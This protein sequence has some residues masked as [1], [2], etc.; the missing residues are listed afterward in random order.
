MVRCL[1][2]VVITLVINF[3]LIRSAEAQVGVM[4]ATR[5]V[6]S[7]RFI[8]APRYIQQELREAE[9]AIEEDRM[10]DAVVRLGDLLQRDTT[11]TADEDLAGQDFFLPPTDGRSGRYTNSKLRRARKLVSQLPTSAIETYELRYGPL[12]RKTLQ[13]AAT[14]RDW[15]AVRDVRRK[16]FHTTA[17]FEASWLLAQH[18]MYTGHPLAASLLLDDVVKLPRAVSYL[19]D[20]IQVLYAAALKLS[21]RSLAEAAMPTSGEVTINGKSVT[22]PTEVDVDEW[23]AT[24]FSYG[25]TRAGGDITSYR[26]FGAQHGRNEI[27]AGQMPLANARWQLETTSTPREARTLEKYAEEL[28]ASSKLPPPS[29]M[30]LRVGDQLLMRTTNYLF[31]VDYNTGK[32]VW[33]YPWYSTDEAFEDEQTP[34]MFSGQRGV[35]SL[36][37][38]RVWNDMPYGQMTSDGRRVFFVD[39]LNEVEAA[40]FSPIMGLQGT[41]PSDNSTNTLVALDLPTE[42]KLLWRLGEGADESSSLSD[43]FFLGPPLPLDGRLYVMVEVAGDILLVCLDSVTGDEIWR[44]QLVA[45]ETGSVDIDITRR[46]SGATPTYSDGVLICPTGAGA[47]VAVDLV[48][49]MLRWGVSYSRRP[50]MQQMMGTRGGSIDPSLLM[51]RWHHG[52]AVVVDDAVFVTPTESDTLM[53]LDLLSGAKRFPDRDREDS[54]YMAGVRDGKILLVGSK[55]LIALDSK[56]GDEQWVTQEDLL[57]PGLQV[58]GRGVFGDNDYLVPTSANQLI[59]IALDDGKV[60]ERRATQYPLGNLLAVDGEVISQGATS[61]SVAYGEA[62]LEPLV[63]AMLK[64]DPTNFEALVRKAELLI[65]RDSRREALKLLQRARDVKSDSVEVRMLSV[66]AMLGLLRE[67]A[68][69]SEQLADQLESMIDRPSERVKFLSLRIRAALKNQEIEQATDRIIQ[70]SALIAGDPLLNHSGEGAVDDV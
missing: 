61:L 25:Q 2:C 47:I 43:A 16:Y 58:V 20:S 22:L 31:G 41:R 35:N 66:A 3:V 10:S 21:G 68:E 7:A 60:L 29:L 18:E 52:V 55:R 70:L 17:G 13:E 24:R 63:N 46:V 51:Q 11:D 30:P 59:R 53:S 28:A 27:S 65:Q 36:L 54:R 67:G 8:E 14:T 5:P 38:Q 12:A 32:R 69:D 50:I 42:G 19:G 26:M 48:D 64:E 1:Y 34:M 39:N 44:Q 40:T 56:T 45:V 49:R 15:N 57:A 37:S 9:R 62:S 23:I 4:R 6:Q 33:N